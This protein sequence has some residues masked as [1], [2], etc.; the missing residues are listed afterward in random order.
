M[1]W[2]SPSQSSVTAARFST[3]RPTA[4]SRSRPKLFPV[5]SRS[6]ACL[7]RAPASPVAVAATARARPVAL[8]V[9]A[10]PPVAR[11]ISMA[12]AKV[13]P[14]PAKAA[15]TTVL[16]V[17][18]GIVAIT[19]T[20][21]TPVLRKTMRPAPRVRTFAP[22]RLARISVRIRAPSSVLTPAHPLHA[23][24]HVLPLPSASP[25]PY[26]RLWASRPSASPAAF[27]SP[28]V[29]VAKCLYRATRRSVSRLTPD[30]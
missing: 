25:V 9:H 3:S 18:R 12:A 11:V 17:I 4:A 27:P 30:R 14:T 23:P 21:A 26:G 2:P 20:T 24:T 7:S 6:N 16:L 29:P 10:N 15:S 19:V 22:Q 5:W 13:R 1:V 28:P 8:A